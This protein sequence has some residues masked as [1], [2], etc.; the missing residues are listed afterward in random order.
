MAITWY[1]F[2]GI[3]NLKK[4][5]LLITYVHYELLP[6]NRNKNR[7]VLFFAAESDKLQVDFQKVEQLEDK[8]TTELVMLKEKNANM[9][10]ELETYSD[11]DKLRDQSEKKRKVNYSTNK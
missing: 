10:K 9:E 7:F 8:I 11:L 4:N 5:D 6:F 3:V 2:S 1:P